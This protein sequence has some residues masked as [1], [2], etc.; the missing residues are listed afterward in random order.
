MLEIPVNFKN[1]NMNFFTLSIGA[2]LII[3]GIIYYFIFN[4]HHKR[5]KIELS[6]L[7]TL[8]TK[9]YSITILSTVLIIIGIYSIIYGNFYKEDRNQVISAVVVGIIIIS[10]TIISYI[11]YIK[12]SLKDLNPEIREKEK[13][14]NI[15]IGEIIQFVFFVFFAF[16]PIWKIPIF[17]KLIEDKKE[18]VI[19]II[20]SLLLCIASLFLLFSLNPLDIKGKIHKKK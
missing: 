12:R 8:V 18:L 5:N 20:K 19:E 14:N 6:E 9:F 13:K 2:Y 15:R 17:L 11:F 10:A 16:T 7:I 1:L 3:L 4:K